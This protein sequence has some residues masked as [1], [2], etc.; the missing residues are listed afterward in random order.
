MAS[1]YEKDEKDVVKKD[2][3]SRKKEIT[4]LVLSRK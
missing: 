2:M 1:N 4:G 3:Y